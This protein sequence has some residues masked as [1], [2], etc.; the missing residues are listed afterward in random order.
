MLLVRVC[1][2]KEKQAAAGSKAQI[3][4]TAA[5]EDGV[6]EGYCEVDMKQD[7][8]VQIKEIVDRNFAS[9]SI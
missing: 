5:G 9:F 2:V 6:S 8:Q 3:D 1:S 4:K 7:R